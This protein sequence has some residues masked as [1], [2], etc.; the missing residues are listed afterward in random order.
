MK[1]ISIVLLS[2]FVIY[3]LSCS[4]TGNPAKNSQHVVE[5]DCVKPIQDPNE[6]KPMARMMRQMANMCDSMKLKL[7]NGLTV[8][9]V[10]FPLM[11]F[12]MAEPTDSTVLEDLF[13][14]H[15]KEFSMAW[16]TL[17][18]DTQNQ[19]VNYTALINKCVSCHMSYCSGPLKRINKLPLD[20]TPEP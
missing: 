17:M 9:S 3:A 6:V 16:R 7:N 11:P 19:K 2:T 4:D 18:S 8:D 20:Y 5:E 12:W 13:F 14:N 15:A 1:K 10:Q